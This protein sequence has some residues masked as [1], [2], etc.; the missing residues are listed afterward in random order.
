MKL[1]RYIG[2]ICFFALALVGCKDKNK[3]ENPEFDK[4]PILTNIADNYIIPHQNE[5]KF[6]LDNLKSA[7][8]TFSADQSS[9]NFDDVKLNYLLCNEQYQRVKMIDFG[10]EMTNSMTMAFGVFPTDTNQIAS[11]ISMGTYDLESAD[12]TDTQGLDALDYL[13]FR[14]DA[15]TLAQTSSNTRAYINDLI[16]KLNNKINL[17]VSGWTTYRS[18]FVSGTGTSQT[19]PFSYLV[20]GCVKDY[21]VTKSTKLGIPLGKA[22]LNIAKPLQFEAKWSGHNKVLLEIS[23]QS[24]S[25]LFHGIGA[26]GTDGQ[27][28]DDYLLAIGRTDLNTSIHNQ[29]Q[30]LTTEIGTW[31]DNLLQRLNSD[32]PS[33]DSYYNYM[34]ALVVNLKTDMPSAFGVVITYQDNDGD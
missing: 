4:S 11:N 15:Y 2:V 22:T 9:T 25:N 34:S 31:N 32:R 33:L 13:L 28:F 17:V 21:E 23:V 16:S 30:Y 19:S 10:P 6:R 8:D 29:F 24:H 18:S 14:T 5:L 20:N 12:N 1:A 27:G 26:D 3:T 7:W